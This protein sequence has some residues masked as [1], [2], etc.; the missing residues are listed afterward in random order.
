MAGGSYW[1]ALKRAFMREFLSMNFVM[2]GMVLVA[3]LLRAS[4]FGLRSEA[5]AAHS[6][7][8]FGS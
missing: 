7:P 5:N 4:G 3:S 6:R 8:H 1:V 2:A